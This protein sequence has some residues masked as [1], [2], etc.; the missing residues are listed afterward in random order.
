M[1]LLTIDD[2]SIMLLMNS[3]DTVIVRFFKMFFLAFDFCRFCVVIRIF[4]PATTANNLRLWTISIP[5]FIHY[6]YCPI[7]IL[8][9]APVFT[10]QCWVLN[11][12]TTGTIFITSLV[13]RGPWLGIEPGTSS[14]RSPH[15][16]TRLSRRR[17]SDLIVFRLIAKRGRE[18]PK[19][20][21]SCRGISG[22]GML[23]FIDICQRCK[24]K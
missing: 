24:N 5:D 1:L 19:L 6:I 3:D 8:L 21:G 13:W 12:G 15:Y 18:E 22:K 10:F 14:T 17:K 7:L 16:T 4:H 2:I 23:I 20:H 9:K 11:K